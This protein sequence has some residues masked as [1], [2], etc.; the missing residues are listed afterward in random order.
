MET[1]NRRATLH[2]RPLWGVFAPRK[3]EGK[4]EFGL[5]LGDFLN[6]GPAFCGNELITIF[7]GLWSVD[8]ACL[9]LEILGCADYLC[10]Q[11]VREFFFARLFIMTLRDGFC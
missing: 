4:C 7:S 10:M 6:Y 8:C 2:V 5:T 11:T 1:C 9:E 3:V